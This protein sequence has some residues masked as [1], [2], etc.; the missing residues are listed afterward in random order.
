MDDYEKKLKELRTYVPFLTKMIDK[1]ETAGDKS[2][3]AQLAKMKSLKEI[4]TAPDKKL[5]LDTLIKCE[6][7][8]HKL[9]EK[10]EGAPMIKTE[11]PKS[12]QRSKQEQGSSLSSYLQQIHD[13]QHQSRFGP[14]GPGKSLS[15]FKVKFQFKMIIISGPQQQRPSPWINNDWQ[16][17]PQRQPAPWAQ[18]PPFHQYQERPN[19]WHDNRGPP[20]S[21]HHHP[22]NQSFQQRFHEPFRDQQ[23]FHE[24]HHGQ[25]P[26]FHSHFG[27]RGPPQQ[28]PRF[29]GDQGHFDQRF[30]R[31]PPSQNTMLPRDR[32]SPTMM[33]NEH[34]GHSPNLR[35]DRGRSPMTSNDFVKEWNKGVRGQVQD[36]PRSPGPVQEDLDTPASPEAEEPETPA[37]PPPVKVD[38][39][40]S[41]EAV[42]TPASPV[43]DTPASPEMTPASPESKGD[44]QKAVKVIPLER[45]LKKASEFD[46][47]SPKDWHRGLRATS[48]TSSASPSSECSDDSDKGHKRLQISSPASSSPASPASGE[49]VNKP[50]PVLPTPIPSTGPVPKLPQPRPA[51]IEGHPSR[52]PRPMD[53]QKPPAQWKSQPRLPKPP[54]QNEF[55]G[56]PAPQQ[57]TPFPITKPQQQEHRKPLT[58][59]EYRRLREEAEKRN[60]QQHEQ[61]NQGGG[62]QPVLNRRDPRR[63]PKPQ[64][65][66]QQQQHT[67]KASQEQSSQS[68]GKFKIPKKKSVEK[69]VEEPKKAEPSKPVEKKPVPE[70]KPPEIHHD[71]SDSEPELKIAESDHED[72][73]KEVE[74]PKKK[75]EEQEVTK[76]ETKEKERGQLTKEMLQNIVANIDTKEASKL[77]ERATR[78]LNSSE[79]G[80]H[81]LS[82]KQLL[83]GDSD[84][85]EETVEKPKKDAKKAKTVAKPKKPAKA[86]TPGTR[87]SRRL[88]T[89]TDQEESVE[90]ELTEEVKDHDDSDDENQL[91]IDE[92]PAGDTSEDSEV[93]PKKPARG[94]PKKVEVK[95]EPVVE[96]IENKTK[97]KS[98]M[99][100]PTATQ[101]KSKTWFP[102]AQDRNKPNKGFKSPDQ[103]LK[104]PTRVQDVKKEPKDPD[105]KVFALSE[106]LVIQDCFLNET[107][108]SKTANILVQ[109]KLSSLSSL[110]SKIDN[111]DNEEGLQDDVKKVEPK[112]S[113]EEL[114]EDELAKVLKEPL[115]DIVFN[116]GSQEQLLDLK[117]KY[118]EVNETDAATELLD[119]IDV[120]KTISDKPSIE[121]HF[122]SLTRQENK[123]LLH[124]DPVLF[125]KSQSS[126]QEIYSQPY[127]LQHLFKC[128]SFHCSFTSDSAQ[129]FKDHLNQMHSPS[130]KKERQGWLKCPYCLRKLGN[131]DFL[132]NHIIR[133]HAQVEQHQCQHCFYRTSSQGSLLVH[134]QLNHPGS[135]NLSLNTSYLEQPLSQDLKLPPYSASVSKGF[136]CQENHCDHQCKSIQSLSDHLYLDHTKPEPYQDFQ[137]PYCLAPHQSLSRLYLHLK[138]SHSKKSSNILHRL[139]KSSINSEETETELS[140]EDTESPDTSLTEQVDKTEDIQDGL[141]GK[142]LFRCGN[143]E[144]EFSAEQVADFRD[145]V[146]ICEYSVDALYLICYHCQKQ[147]KHVATL[148]D[149]MKTHGRKRYS[150]SL[151]S[152]FKNAVPLYVRNHL[153]LSHNVQQSK[154]VPVD[155]MKTNPD[156]DYFIVIPKNALPKGIR[157]GSSGK[158]TIDTFSPSEIALIPKISMFRNLIRC[159]VCD[160]VT[161][162]RLN[163]VKHLKLHL[164][165]QDEQKPVPFITPV[166]PVESKSESAFGKM[167]A[168][169]DLSEEEKLKRPMPEEELNQMP[170]WVAENARFACPEKYCNYVTVD[171]FMLIAHMEHIH[172]EFKN[173]YKCPHCLESN[174]DIPF[175]EVEFHLRCHGELLF[176]CAHCLYYH[177]QKRTAEKHVQDEHPGQK[178][179]ARDVRAEAVEIKKSKSEKSKKGKDD[180]KLVPNA[181]PEVIS[182]LPYKCGLC[183]H[184]SETLELIRAHCSSSHDITNQFKC[185]LC[186]VVSDNKAQVENHC[187]STHNSLSVMMRIYYVDPS[188]ST[189]SGSE[190]M[191]EKREPLW[192]RDMPGLKHIRGILYEEY[193]MAAY[194]A[195]PE[196]SKSEVK[197]NVKSSNPSGNKNV[198]EVDN[199]PMKCKECGLQKKTIKGLKMHIKLL[200]LRTGKFLCQRCQFSANMLN[201]INTHYKIKHPEAADKPDY[202]ERS[203]DKMI[204]SHEF[205]KEKWNIP[206]LAERKAIVGARAKTSNISLD[207]GQSQH[208]DDF[209]DEIVVP[210]K[211]R[212]K[213]GTSAPAKKGKY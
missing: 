132:T 159:S 62:R 107:V 56:P 17:R 161:K 31:G 97:P 172:P 186:D 43:D 33:R 120:V 24:P 167:M 190:L 49:S 176:K 182:Y 100:M 169:L 142:E 180:K 10:V 165:L 79:D 77:L 102:Q 211:K 155:C 39:P 134:S 67:E 82:L 74:E 37:S 210:K 106:S 122:T 22:P 60:R 66:P 140:G 151:C 199:F 34:R 23:R 108:Q 110:F 158:A 71:E 143:K 183:E 85:E 156:K 185:S 124:Q 87:R 157:S 101:K 111:L 168:L 88:Q 45:T 64:Q 121:D 65:P 38:T 137:C 75:E 209:D 54:S 90:S 202:E 197:T 52:P 148:V 145:H 117:E 113:T 84:S 208:L 178:I 179:F 198:D 42:E 188:S 118:Q 166:N 123:G 13:S 93:S 95:V 50:P 80:N 130:P 207:R 92:T 46:I 32:N 98:K 4:L 99:M 83:V 147:S 173:I 35:E 109:P 70:E 203:D 127:K 193:P 184:A 174:N 146:A 212:K 96:E 114:Q 119:F 141:E 162:V 51:L 200:H 25:R 163:L 86:P 3:A 103:A 116:E 112:S 5:R 181:E 138:L 191:D 187:E 160:F 125:H 150:C 175:D 144:C 6:D 18:R 133:D 8:L 81:K 2:K 36:R 11:R 105:M 58:Y 1:I 7:V 78:L 204:F 40:M 177:W 129:E 30:H 57:R 170:I 126:I 21:F 128:M 115:P 192:R 152:S 69:V 9:Y 44:D 68:I 91:V 131:P 48:A 195:Q 153:R 29:G 149:H 27:N 26:P 76:E 28:G 12:P 205:W 135:E 19:P 94:R 164:R 139:I 72:E 189:N 59:G 213:G 104:S 196:D 20:S 154:I 53:Q 73:K 41:P 206:T 61:Q 16:Q 14:R 136:K 63:Q 55:A 201:S 194:E 47:R 15:M 171:A 89:P